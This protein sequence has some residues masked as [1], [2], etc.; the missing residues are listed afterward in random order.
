M[1]VQRHAGARREV[2]HHHQFVELPGHRE[3]GEGRLVGDGGAGGRRA[4]GQR[5]NRQRQRQGHEQRRRD[6]S[7]QHRTPP[8]LHPCIAPVGRCA[9]GPDHALT[10]G[11]RG[12]PN[13]DRND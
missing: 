4:V 11:A 12:A 10:I 1:H 2:E 5:A 8:E 6:A 7:S 9:D 3:V 13:I